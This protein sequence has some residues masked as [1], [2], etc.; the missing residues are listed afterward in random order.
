M[1]DATGDAQ[2]GSKT[3]LGATEAEWAELVAALPEAQSRFLADLMAARAPE[4]VGVF[5]HRLMQNGEASPFLSQKVVQERLNGA[6]AAWL[7]NLFRR[8]ASDVA[9]FMAEQRTIGAVHAR[10]AVPIHVVMQGARLLKNEI[11]RRLAIEV[12]DRDALSRLTLHVDN[13]IDIAIEVM[14]QAFVK[15]AGAR[16]RNDEAYRAFALSH[17]FPL[18]RES[19]RAALMEWSQSLLFNLYGDMAHPLAPLSGSDFGLWLQHKAELMFAGAP[20]LEAIR[21]KAA[22]V[23]AA[24]LPAVDGARRDD[25]AALPA[26]L[27]QFQAAIGEIKFLLSELFQ[28]AATME[29]GRDPLTRMLNRR[30]LPSILSREVRMAALKSMD[31][32][33]LMIDI[34]HFKRINDRFGHGGGD[35]VLQQA[36]ETILSLCRAS[37]FVFRYGG[38]EFLIALVETDEDAAMAIAEELRQRLAAQKLK[39]PDGTEQ[40]VTLS[41]GVSSFNGHPDYSHLVDAADRALYRAKQSGRNRCEK[42]APLAPHPDLPPQAA[43]SGRSA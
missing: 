4:F 31:F 22:D 39:L 35:A 29:A 5:Y 13:L 8:G 23:D 25:P 1:D 7:A 36:A 37:D 11:A 34:D 18:E 43:A 6:L 12:A 38:E 30:F 42:E 32:S 19:Q 27:A 33:V 26:A 16:V 21:R 3:G 24:L 40:S 17:D 9:A 20:A 10:I 15:D 14:S 2:W 28:A 41:I